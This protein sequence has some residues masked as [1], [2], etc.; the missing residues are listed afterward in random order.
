MLGFCAVI[1]AHKEDKPKM[2]VQKSFPQNFRTEK[3]AFKIL[4]KLTPG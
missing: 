4:V 3:V 2:K 1:F